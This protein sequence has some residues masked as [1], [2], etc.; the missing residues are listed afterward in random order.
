M[1]IVLMDH[2]VNADKHDN[3]LFKTC[4]KLKIV[5]SVNKFIRSVRYKLC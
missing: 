5:I 4:T 2:P 3:P 1:C